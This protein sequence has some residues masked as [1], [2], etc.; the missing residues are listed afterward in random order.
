MK[1]PL[2]QMKDNS[3]LQGSSTGSRNTIKWSRQRFVGQYTVLMTIWEVYFRSVH[4]PP[5]LIA[6][7][8]FP[9]LK[10]TT[11]FKAHNLNMI[12]SIGDISILRTL[13]V[14]PLSHS[15]TYDINDKDTR[16][17]PSTSS[18]SRSYHQLLRTHRKK[19]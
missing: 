3:T 18:S 19:N 11:R 4:S 16:P 5:S 9:R 13:N 12:K 6:S 10:T 15:A 14:S 2:Y 7:Y 8:P 17:S 1:S